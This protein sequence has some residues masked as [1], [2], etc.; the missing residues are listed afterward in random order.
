MA[1]IGLEIGSVAVKLVSS[2]LD[3]EPAV[4]KYIRHEGNFRHIVNHDLRADIEK[5]RVAI[6]GSA[7][8]RLLDF[9]YFPE[10][11]CLEAAIRHYDVHPAILLTLGGEK[12]TLY[13][14]RNGE[15]CDIHKCPLCAAGGGSFPFQQ[16]NRMGFT[17]EEGMAASLNGRKVPLAARCSVYCKSDATHKLNK[18]ECSPADI[19]RS[20]VED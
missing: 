13:T 9:P 8:K 18:G 4:I 2:G 10:S 11:D 3:H 20:L 14:L 16:F 19:C 12:F 15:I 6:T 17:P 7:A 1:S 5:G